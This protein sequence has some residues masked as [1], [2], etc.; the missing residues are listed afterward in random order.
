MKNDSPFTVDGKLSKAEKKR[1]KPSKT[2]P[3]PRKKA[4]TRHKRGETKVGESRG[5]KD[6]KNEVT[7]ERIKV[8]HTFDIFKDQLLSIKEIALKREKTF[9]K[10]VRL[11]DIFKEALDMFITKERLN[12][13]KTET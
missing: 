5:P 6:R 3:L 7:K 10:K 1:K 11:G 4:P 12:E 8:R 13:E 2:T 9:D